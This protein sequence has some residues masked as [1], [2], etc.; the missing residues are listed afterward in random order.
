MASVTPVGGT[1]QVQARRVAGGQPSAGDGAERGSRAGHG[2]PGT[3]PGGVF[4]AAMPPAPVVVIVG[5]PGVAATPAELEPPSTIRSGPN[6]WTHGLLDSRLPGLRRLPHARAFG[7]GAVATKTRSRGRAWTRFSFRA[8]RGGRCCIF[9][10]A[11]SVEVVPCQA[12]AAH[13]MARLAVARKYG[14]DQTLYEGLPVLVPV[15][16]VPPG[17]FR[18]PGAGEAPLGVLRLLR[19]A[20]LRAPMARARGA[21]GGP[22]RPRARAFFDRCA[23]SRRRREGTAYPSPSARRR[24]RGAPKS[25]SSA[26]ACRCRPRVEGPAQ[27]ER[28][29]GSRSAAEDVDG[30][31]ADGNAQA[32]RRAKVA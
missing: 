9:C 10:L 31:P 30:C 26:A 23:E 5:Q 7:G 16:R 19:H 28:R 12:L 21:E 32:T 13:T 8:D 1:F 4:E 15:L 18:G 2:S 22:S 3:P 20:P 25:H 14:I 6:A 11:I 29:D 24:G 17:R 27:A